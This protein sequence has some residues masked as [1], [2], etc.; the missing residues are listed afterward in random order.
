MGTSRSKLLL[1]ESGVY[2]SAGQ[3]LS[4]KCMVSQIVKVWHVVIA[5]T[6][7]HGTPEHRNTTKHP[8]TPRNTPEHP[9]HPEQCQKPRNTF[10]K[11][12][13]IPE[14]L[15][16]NPEH[17][18]TPFR[19][20]GTPYRKPVIGPEIPQKCTEYLNKTRNTLSPHPPATKN[21]RQKFIVTTSPL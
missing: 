5:G 8:G 15:P 9:E 12:R 6:P 7:E 13:N 17:P 16:E 1:S 20:P 11:T 2:K 19:K 4:Q 21:S 14:Q 18:R 3:V 10:Q